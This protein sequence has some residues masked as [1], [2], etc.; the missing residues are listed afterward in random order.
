ML[1]KLRLLALGLSV[2][3]VYP[4][5]HAEVLTITDL[6]KSSSNVGPTTFASSSTYL[7]N[8]TDHT[9]TDYSNITE[10]QTELAVAPTTTLPGLEKD[11]EVTKIKYKDNLTS[12]KIEYVQVGVNAPDS[13]PAGSKYLILSGTVTSSITTNVYFDLSAY[14]TYVPG[15]SP[16]GSAVPALAS[17]YLGIDQTSVAPTPASYSYAGG[18]ANYYSATSG[19]GYAHGMLAGETL[20]FYAAVFAPND[21]SLT[22]LSLVVRTDY[23]GY[24][25]VTTPY[26]SET[27]NLVEARALPPLPVPENA[28]YAMLL[29]G[30]GMIGFIR[31]RRG[32]A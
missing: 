18:G 16:F 28:T 14:G 17:L 10:I 27:R 13:T 15:T 23:Y 30:L 21:A 26:E 31:R 20:T 7:S 24:Q 22:D 5:A 29:A 8:Y 11:Y 6:T 2:L 32:K 3:A 12:Y 9:I 1:Q 25:T 4:Q 19:W